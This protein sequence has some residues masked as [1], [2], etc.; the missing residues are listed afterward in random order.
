MVVATD[1]DEE[2]EESIVSTTEMHEETGDEAA[3]RQEPES[4]VPEAEAPGVAET[5]LLDDNE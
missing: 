5:L 1:M 4:E 3:E 2:S